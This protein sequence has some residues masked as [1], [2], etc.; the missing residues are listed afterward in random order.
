MGGIRV[1]SDRSEGLDLSDRLQAVSTGPALGL[2]KASPDDPNHPGWPPGTEGSLG[3]KFRPKIGDTFTGDASYYGTD[4]DGFAGLPMANRQKM[5]PEAMTGAVRP[6]RIPLGSGVRVSLAHNPSHSI[7]VTVTDHGMVNISLSRK[8]QRWVPEPGTEG[9]IIDLTPRAFQAL[10]GSTKA[11]VVAVQVQILSLSKRI[12][13][14][15]PPK[16]KTEP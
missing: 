8:A 14:F 3:G 7:V 1:Q 11:G 13:Y 9:R 5:N 16:P 10:T 15:P 4:G 12:L 2:L 6:N